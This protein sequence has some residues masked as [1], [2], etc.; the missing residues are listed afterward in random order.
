MCSAL[1]AIH[2][3]LTSHVHSP[4]LPPQ[5]GFAYPAAD[6][7]ENEVRYSLP[8]STRTNSAIV[9]AP[10]LLVSAGLLSVRH[11]IPATSAVHPADWDYSGV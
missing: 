7:G 9:I 1:H 10:L 8:P 11:T 4:S 6:W 2:G 3:R 5:E